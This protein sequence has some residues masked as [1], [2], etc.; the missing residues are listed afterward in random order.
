MRVSGNIVD[1]FAS[2]VYPGTIEITDGR[3][4]GIRRDRG[5][6]GVFIV[7]GLVDAH[8]HIESSMMVPSEFA[9]LAVTH[10][11]V[12]SVSDP[13]E[14]ANVL[15][16]KGVEYMIENGR[17]SPFKFWF[18]APS[19]VPATP[20]ETAG[21]RIG[22]SDIESLFKSDE[23]KYLSE[24]M[25]FP[26]VLK[27]ER[28]VMEKIGIAA[29]LGK[30]VDGHAPGLVGEPL[31]RY[32]SAG[33]STDHETFQYEEG[34]E[35]LALGMKLIIREG[36]AAKNFDAL[37]PLIARYPAQC[38]F[39]SDDKHPDDL[40]SGHIN[41]LVKKGLRAGIDLMTLLRCASA[42]PVSHYGLNVGLLRVGD[43]ADFL[44]VANL[45]R[46]DVLK[47]YINGV[48][49]AENGVTLLA[50]TP[51]G[52]ANFFKAGPKSPSDF[53][54]KGRGKTVNVIEAIDN[55][56]ITGRMK[57][58]VKS[59]KGGNLVSD[60]ERDTLKI[61]V[62]NRYEDLP[63]AI[64]FVRNFGLRKG[65]IASSVA[66]D[67]HN[68]IAVGVT[69][70][71]ICEAVNLI[72]EAKGGLAVVHEHVREVLPLPVA[73]LMSDD[74]GTSVAKSYGKLDHLAKQLGS[75][76]NAPFMTL[77]FM[78]LLVIPKLKLSDKGL[79]D[80]EKFAFTDLFD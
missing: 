40:V 15:G 46:F 61:A 10:G 12:A 31:R 32:V 58:P 39:C 23:V 28:D 3:I 19:C 36:S 17:T 75:F 65:A 9:R 37:C 45:A 34:E 26:G 71:D 76:L 50:R 67:S 74:E 43:P 47:T 72:V 42:N 60:T 13:H 64:G 55:Q 44:E 35:K 18:G 25:N 2:E 1:I 52:R 8:V 49:A 11:T 66:H 57:G 7:P 48:V 70:E 22:P 16:I 53:A 54:V 63:P 77:S 62:V 27:A 5:K 38:M 51:S 6:H 14:I 30:P 21:A 73:G 4:A 56:V 20:F 79:F 29:R 24:V 33:I 69:D 59:V 41:E 78:A 68:I 80:G